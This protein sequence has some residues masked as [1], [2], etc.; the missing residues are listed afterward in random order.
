MN[1]C[2]IIIL[3]IVLLNF[4]NPKTLKRHLTCEQ[5]EQLSRQVRMNKRSILHEDSSNPALDNVTTGNQYN[6]H[7]SRDSPS[8]QLELHTLSYEPEGYTM[9]L[10][11][12][13][14]ESRL[15]S[16]VYD[17]TNSFYD[18]YIFRIRFHGKLEYATEKKLIQFGVNG[19]NQLLLK[20][21][22]DYEYIVCVTLFSNDSSVPPLSTTGLLSFYFLFFQFYVLII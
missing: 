9:S 22:D 10:T 6:K 14:S 12:I 3:L 18:K 4:A 13:N 2:K 5:Q 21:F 7:N 8:Y 1:V 20:K 11:E 17:K 19:T 15:V 16:F